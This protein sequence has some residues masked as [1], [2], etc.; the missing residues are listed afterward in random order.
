[1][2]ELITTVVLIIIAGFFIAAIWSLWKRIDFGIED[3]AKFT[4]KLNKL[5]ASVD[6]KFAW[7]L[8]QDEKQK[9]KEE[10]EANAPPP[11][12][13]KAVRKRAKKGK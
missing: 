1:M 4:R 9:A 13:F 6:W 7:I 5:R 10:Q 12:R 8:R 2:G 3:H 11:N